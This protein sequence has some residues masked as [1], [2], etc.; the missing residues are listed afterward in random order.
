VL[1]RL[2]AE[3]EEALLPVLRR[4]R[5]ELAS[6]RVQEKADRSL[7]TEADLEVERIIISAIRRYDPGARIV[8][9]ESGST[10]GDASTDA[11]G[12]RAWVVDPIDGTAEFVDVSRSE[13][14]SVVCLLE[15]GEPRAA[16]VLAPELGVG[17]SALSFVVDRTE[18]SVKVNGSFARA[19]AMAARW[20]SVTRSKGTPS[21]AFEEGLQGMG[22][23]LK[24]RTTSQTIDMLRTAVDLDPYSDLEPAA[25]RLFYREQ[26]KVWDGAAGICAGAAMGM[27]AVGPD[28]HPRT[29]VDPS[30][31]R[32]AEPTFD[33]TVMG[34]PGAVAWLLEN[35]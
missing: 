1:E 14:C 16:Y 12:S 31:L 25:F 18:A 20:A 28:G 21:R 6:L 29:P 26:Q 22:L 33:A 15:D 13:F 32:L 19:P 8:A 9:E 30:F 17:R 34:E 10:N 4:Y 35:L 5:S 23:D 2:W 11:D 24:T 7:L 27:L 3:L